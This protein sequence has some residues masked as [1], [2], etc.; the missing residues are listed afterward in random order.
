MAHGRG[1]VRFKGLRVLNPGCR[2]Q[3]RA[4]RTG[5]RVTAISPGIVE[6]EFYQV[7][8]FNDRDRAQAGSPYQD[9]QCLQPQDIAQAVV[10]ALSAPDHVDVNDILVR[11][12]QQLL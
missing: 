2:A 7:T 3:A 12:T 1:W 9:F 8:Q 11:P 4:R 5:L 10:W 6:T